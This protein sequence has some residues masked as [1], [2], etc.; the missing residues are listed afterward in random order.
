M[1]ITDY[2]PF[3]RQ[4]LADDRLNDLGPGTP[5]QPVQARL[6]TLTLDSAFAPKRVRDPVMA[7][8]CLAA[9]WLYHDFLEES[10]R[11]SQELNTVEGGYWHG[12][13]HRREPDFGNSKYWFHNVG[14]HPVFA[15]LAREAAALAGATPIAG[16]EFLQKQ[17]EW[18]PFKFIDL[19]QAATNGDAD[20]VL[21]CRQIQRREWEL[22]FDYCYRAAV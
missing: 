13:M 8:A 2:S 10:H 18:D 15:E 21:L 16:A 1:T 6:K 17:K 14:K 9:I 19:C 12:L 3:F 22:L 20:A 4:L 11:I 7:R 5:N